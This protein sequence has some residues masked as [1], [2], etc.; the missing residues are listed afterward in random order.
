MPETT[1]PVSVHPAIREGQLRRRE[2]E[3][4]LHRALIV[5]GLSVDA[6]RAVV[7]AL[8]N[9]GMFDHAARAEPQEPPGDLREAMVAAIDRHE[10]LWIDADTGWECGCNEHGAGPL[11][12]TRADATGHIADVILPVVRAHVADQVRRWQVI[13]GTAVEGRRVAIDKAGRAGAVEA[14]RAAAR[15]IDDG[16]GRVI[17]TREHILHTAEAGEW[18]RQLADATETGHDAGLK[19]SGEQ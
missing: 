14:L 15:R 9:A 19:I 7:V 11:M 6:I 3:R 13:A 4:V 10:V 16:P 1:E 8:D 17:G 18:L 12:P 2:A 5:D